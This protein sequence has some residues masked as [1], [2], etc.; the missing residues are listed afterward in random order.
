MNK[1]LRAYRIVRGFGAFLSRRILI[2]VRTESQLIKIDENQILKRGSSEG[3]SFCFALLLH[4][5]Y[6]VKL[7]IFQSG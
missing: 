1:L 5:L 3:L 2:L 4:N 6:Y 7:C